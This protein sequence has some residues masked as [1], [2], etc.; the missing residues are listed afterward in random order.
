MYW[1]LINEFNKIA[2]IPIILNT[3]FNCAE[4]PIVHTPENAI[5]DFLRTSLDVLVLENVLIVKEAG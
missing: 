1:E 3:S 4:E 5:E 2:G